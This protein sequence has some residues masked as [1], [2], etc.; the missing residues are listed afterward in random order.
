MSKTASTKNVFVDANVLIYTFDS[1]HKQKN[2]LASE[3][4]DYLWTSALGRLS[5]QVLNEFYVNVTQKLKPGIPKLVAQNEFRKYYA[6]NPLTTN[7]VLIET[8]WTAQAKYQLSWWDALIF[9][10]ARVSKCEILL[11]ED[12]QTGQTLDGV[13]IISPFVTKPLKLVTPAR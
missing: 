13:E 5:F 11:T 6:W 4:L 12:F 2:Q 9:A 8:A 1:S 7:E 3:W 10:A